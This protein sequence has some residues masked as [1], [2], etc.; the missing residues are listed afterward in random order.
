MIYLNDLS[1]YMYIPK[2][3]NESSEK[4]I[5]RIKSRINLDTRDIVMN[6]ENESDTPLYYKLKL[7]DVISY[8]PHGEYEFTLYGDFGEEFEHGLVTIG[9]YDREYKTSYTFDP[10]FWRK[11]QYNDK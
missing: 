11:R 9:D 5:V 10:Y 3:N 2:H 1:D 6:Q 7:A 8:L 4:Y